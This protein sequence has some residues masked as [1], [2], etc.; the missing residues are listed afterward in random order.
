[1]FYQARA[2]PAYLGTPVL[3]ARPGSNQYRARGS[4]APAL[5]PAGP[6]GGIF[7]PHGTTGVTYNTFAAAA[8][9]RDCHRRAWAAAQPGCPPEL[10]SKLARD[11]AQT[12][13]SAVAANPS[14]PPDALA[15]L[16]LED[17]PNVISSR[18]DAPLLPALQAVKNQYCPPEALARLYHSRTP[19]EWR[20]AKLFAIIGRRMV[21]RDSW[22]AQL[23]LCVA[24][25]PN[26]P[27]DILLELLGNP[28][29]DIRR[30]AAGN[31]GLSKAALAMWQLTH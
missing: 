1:M 28:G 22:G 27:Q 3:M 5:I 25:N 16:A 29:Q 23:L 7:V 8:R 6:S 9:D 26:T 31:P 2:A 24:N 17:P 11:R 12:V 10:L 13:R 30:A 18:R 4:K 19:E 15:R 21:T 14:C 20:G